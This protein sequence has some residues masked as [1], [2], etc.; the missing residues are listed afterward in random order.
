MKPAG[1][2]DMARPPNKLNHEM[3]NESAQ[4]LDLLERLFDVYIQEVAALGQSYLDERDRLM[5]T[6][7]SSFCYGLFLCCE[8]KTCNQ[9]RLRFGYLYWRAGRAR[10]NSPT[11]RANRRRSTPITRNIHACGEDGAYTRTNLRAA[12]PYARMWEFELTC[13][14][15][16]EAHKI[17][18]FL[19]AMNA[20]KRSLISFP[21]PPVIE[22]NPKKRAATR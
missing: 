5:A 17:R 19:R 8:T 1:G 15:E 11:S 22:S 6:N 13:R 4:Q 3:I 2:F 18:K 12:M 16:R 14:Y 10:H 7:G 21:L 20:W 9:T